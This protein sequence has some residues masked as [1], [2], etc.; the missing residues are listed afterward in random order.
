MLPS[1][2][3]T[4]RHFGLAGIAAV[5]ACAACCALPFLAAAGIGGGVL[6]A[7]AGY[8][9]PGAD[10]IV[11][12]VVGAGML[13][14]LAFQAR[15]RVRA[16]RSAECDVGC[17]LQGGCGCGPTP[18]QSI[19]V[20][21]EPAANEP[22]VCTA[23]LDNKPT[24][25][26]QLDGY[27]AAFAQLLRSEKLPR[28]FRWV[29]A[30]RPGLEAELR[31]LAEKEHQCCRFFKFELRSIGD[32]VTWEVTGDER[33][34]NALKAFEQLPEHLARTPREGDALAIK[35]AVTAAGLVFAAD[36]DRR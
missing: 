34:E 18:D 14:V 29:F 25:Q 8:L 9:R 28:G 20:T 33:A 1:N 23:D 15:R 4:K 12:G 19:F 31:T 26:G 16:A 5:V 13:G 21:A 3:F 10:L 35:Q 30:T 32:V 22:I 17:S 2:P 27:R 24:V 6:S 36:R 11:G 7:A